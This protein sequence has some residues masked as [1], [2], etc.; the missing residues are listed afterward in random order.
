MPQYN[1]QTINYQEF[2]NA[3]TDDVKATEKAGTSVYT[4]TS[5]GSTTSVSTTTTC[6][7]K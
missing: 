4:S 7:K 5:G 1:S 3:T 2:C 6:N